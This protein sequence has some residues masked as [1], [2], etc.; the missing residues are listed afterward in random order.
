MTDRT[1]PNAEECEAA[2]A[3]AAYEAWLRNKVAA[4]VSDTRPSITHSEMEHR[5]QQRIQRLR[6]SK[7]GS[8]DPDSV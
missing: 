1:S 3:K 8:P 7:A 5:M 6:A 4:S 2:K